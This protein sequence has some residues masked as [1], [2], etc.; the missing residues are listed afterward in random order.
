MQ[1]TPSAHDRTKNRGENILRLL[2][3]VFDMVCVH[4]E[5]MVGTVRKY[6]SIHTQCVWDSDRRKVEGVVFPVIKSH[7]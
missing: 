5:A 3:I 6:S 1:C 7:K 4:P 2:Y